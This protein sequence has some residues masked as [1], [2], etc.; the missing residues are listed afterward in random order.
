MRGTS[1]GTSLVWDRYLSV[2]CW[3][4]WPTARTQERCTCSSSRSAGP[5]ATWHVLQTPSTS[6]LMDL[7]H[8]QLCFLVRRLLPLSF[9]YSDQDVPKP[10]PHV[11]REFSQLEV[12]VG[13]GDIFAGSNVVQVEF[14]ALGALQVAL[15]G[16]KVAAGQVKGLIGIA[17]HLLKLSN[18]GRAAGRIMA[19][20]HGGVVLIQL[21]HPTMFEVV[22]LAQVF[23]TSS[24][25]LSS[26]ATSTWT[27]LAPMSTP[28]TS[29]TVF[30]TT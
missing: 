9:S 10:V 2:G 4:S 21:P 15:V 26:T 28:D 18:W 14:V 20:T 22:F 5:A 27:G 3:S 1:S 11:Q 16:G 7:L 6:V 17:A 29:A 8:P 13:G 30:F 24:S 25:A 12:Q 23:S 19:H